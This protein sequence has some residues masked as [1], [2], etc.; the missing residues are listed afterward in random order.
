ML[1]SHKIIG[2]GLDLNDHTFLRYLRARSYDFAKGSAMLN[3][4]LNWRR[5][6]GLP[7]IHGPE[8][9]AVV[10]KENATGK[11]Y[12]RGFDKEGSVIMYMKP[13]FE[14]TSDHDGNLKHLVY[15]MEK[16]VA[17][18]NSLTGQ[19]KIALIIDYDG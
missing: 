16:A 4:T 8:W 19:E 10:A 12:V 1:N 3:E 7:N 14:N 2:Y 18:M 13:K 11:T 17:C 6:F 9:Q 5:D 15:N